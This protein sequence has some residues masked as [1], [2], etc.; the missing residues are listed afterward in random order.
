MPV[1]VSGSQGIALVKAALRGIRWDDLKSHRDDGGEELGLF[2]VAIALG[3][4]SLE[5]FD[6]PQKRLKLIQEEGMATDGPSI[7]HHR[8]VCG[9]PPGGIIPRR[10][11]HEEPGSVF[12][13]QRGVQVHFNVFDQSEGLFQG[14]GGESREARRMTLH[15]LLQK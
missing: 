3:I 12:S 6:F 1:P 5:G 4:R 14:S 11:A 8:G 2:L 7:D 10:A 13:C 15:I 9:Y